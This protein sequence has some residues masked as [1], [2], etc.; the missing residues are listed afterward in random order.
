MA[1]V[2]DNFINENKYNQTKLNNNKMYKFK[3]MLKP[4]LSMLKKKP[5]KNTYQKSVDSLEECCYH[6]TYYNQENLDN[7]KLYDDQIMLEQQSCYHAED[8]A[9]ESDQNDANELLESQ[10]L[11]EINTCGENQG[12]PVYYNQDTMEII[13]I[14]RGQHYVPVHFAKTPAGTFFWT[15]MSTSTD[16]D[17]CCN[18][19]ETENQLPEV[20]VPQDRWAQA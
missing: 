3:K 15:T 8:S 6:C 18:Q 1:L 2:H 10:I 20:Q 17:L 19:S 13:P 4:V 7:M 5:T 14:V 9:Y 11:S 16:S 12:V